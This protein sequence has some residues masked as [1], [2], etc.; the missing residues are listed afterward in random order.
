MQKVE[1]TS[2]K[3]ITK[4]AKKLLKD[5]LLDRLFQ[6]GKLDLILKDGQVFFHKLIFFFKCI[7]EF[8][9]FFNMLKKMRNKI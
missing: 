8:Q 5:K 3:Y 2:N 9:I 6:N 1:E 4:K 7:F